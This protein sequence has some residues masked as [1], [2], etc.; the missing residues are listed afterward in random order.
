MDD[1][2]Y[3][4]KLKQ[5]G[6][7]DQVIAEKMGK[8]ESA[9]AAMWEEFLATQSMYGNGY[10]ILVERFTTLCLQY[11]LVGESLKHIAGI[12][13]NRVTIQEMKREVEGKDKEAAIAALAN[14]FIILKRAE[15]S[16]S[17]PP[18]N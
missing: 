6:L 13:S 3:L 12:L 5:I 11:E 15:P 8:S 9:V 17:P 10:P 2:H 1:L 18:E 16:T 4:I 7:A 14:A